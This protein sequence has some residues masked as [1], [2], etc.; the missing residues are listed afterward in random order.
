MGRLVSRGKG[1]EIGE[2]SEE[3]WGKGIKF[4]MYIR[5]ISN[6]NLKR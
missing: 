2:V 6:K 1:D 4:E 3:K 5:K